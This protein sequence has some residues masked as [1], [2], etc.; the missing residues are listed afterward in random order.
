LLVLLE[1]VH[2]HHIA[3]L[4]SRSGF[5][6]DALREID[7]AVVL[8]IENAD[9]LQFRIIVRIPTDMALR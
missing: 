8:A 7:S 4:A 6:D 1:Q 5:A 3:R 2:Q 9:R